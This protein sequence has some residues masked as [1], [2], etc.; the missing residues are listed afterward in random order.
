LET[1]FVTKLPSIERSP[2]TAQDAAIWAFSAIYQ[3]KKATATPSIKKY[4][5]FAQ[6]YHRSGTGLPTSVGR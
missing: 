6:K 2:S 3:P 1:D 4:K 5:C